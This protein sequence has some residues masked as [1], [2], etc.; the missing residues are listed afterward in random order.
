[1]A[2]ALASVGVAAALGAAGVVA[3]APATGASARPKTTTVVATETDF[4]IAL[5][6]KTFS[7]GRYTFVAKNKGQTTHGIMVTGPGLSNA[8]SKL[9]QPG[10]STKLTVTLKKGRY[11]LYC[12]VPG[13][14]QL[15]MNVG[16][17]VRG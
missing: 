7:P 1:V 16:L 14:K 12:Q 9:I 11:D 15:G 6:K 8:M 17:T 5:S 2:A 3:A 10:Q 4:H 13:H